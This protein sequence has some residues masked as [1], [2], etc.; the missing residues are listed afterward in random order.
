MAVTVNAQTH[1]KDIMGNWLMYF[2]TNRVSEKFSIHSEVQYR[3]HTVEP[4]NIEQLLLRT[5]LNFHFSE[6]AFVTGGYGHITSHS[7]AENQQ[8]PDS[9]EH[10]IWQQ[11]IMN[12]KLGRIKF[13]HRYRVEQ[14]W[15]DDVYKNRFRYRLMVFAPLNSDKVEEGTFFLG[16]YDEIFVNDRREFFDRNRIYGAVGYQFRDNAGFQLGLLNQRVNDFGKWYLQ[17]GLVFNTDF[18][19]Q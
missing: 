15:I 6:K 9:R 13:E 17:L 19:Q 1:T 10:R 11:L 12:S 14:R 4:V 18:R 16:L 8:G 2:G 3:N 7:Y 5:G